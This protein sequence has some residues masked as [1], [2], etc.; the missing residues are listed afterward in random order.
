MQSEL[1]LNKMLASK[2]IAV[3]R[4]VDPS[5]IH[6]LV[7]SL[8]E[9][10]ISTIEIT[11][12]SKESSRII[13]E[14][15][16]SFE[17]K[18]TIGAGTVL[19]KKQAEEAITA[20]SEFIFSPILDKETITYVK[21]KNIIMIP[22]VFTPTEMQ[23]AFEWGT[24][25]VKVF[26]ANVLGPSFFKDVRGP[27]GHIAKIPTG[28]IHLGNVQDFL[29]AGAVAVGVGSSLVN[30]TLIEQQNWTR[31]QQLAEQ[32]VHVANHVTE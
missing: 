17:K 30:Q 3:I 20:G 22:G 23:K 6:E 8:V 5:K 2:I 1:I 28:G 18:A 31:I 14:L 15:R 13:L 21:S 7:S 32:F 16:Q 12:D 9:G 26:P 25:I 24:E 29:K 19:N 4:K 10:G 27:L 11:M